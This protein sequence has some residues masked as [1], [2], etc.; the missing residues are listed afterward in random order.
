MALTSFRTYGLIERKAPGTENILCR[1]MPGSIDVMEK[2]REDSVLYDGCLLFSL[3]HGNVRPPVK[4]HKY[5]IWLIFI[6][7]QGNVCDMCHGTSSR[8]SLPLFLL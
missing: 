4:R 7:C 6:R 8:V 1:V 5:L 2:A 3:R